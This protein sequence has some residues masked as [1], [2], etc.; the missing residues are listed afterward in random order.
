ME[1]TQD[2]DEDKNNLVLFDNYG[3]SRLHAICENFRYVLRRVSGNNHNGLKI[4]LYAAMKE[5]WVTVGGRG[6]GRL[7]GG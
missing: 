5:W 4:Y 2:G 3:S 1:N 7:N 6:G